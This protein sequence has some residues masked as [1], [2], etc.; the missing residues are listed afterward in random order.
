MARRSVVFTSIA[1]LLAVSVATIVYAQQQKSLKIDV[2]LVMVNVTVTDGDNKLITDLKPD[3]FHIFEDKVEQKIRYFSTEQQ[4]LSLGIVFD[5]SHSMEPKI[6]LAREAAARF[7]ETGGPEDEYFLVEFSSRAKLTEHF[8]SDVARL[9]D[10][11]ALVPP[12][13]DTAMYDAVYLA[14]SEVR[15]GR[16]PKKALLLIT[17]GEDNHSRYSRH[18]IREFARE[19]D[20]QIFSIDLGRALIA[21]LSDMTG[22]H[23]FHGHPDQLEDI[24]GKI[25]QELKN[26]YVV[27]YASTNT[28][29]DGKYRK[30]RV[31][32]TPP[33]GMPK[34]NVRT[35]DGY[36]G[37][38]SPK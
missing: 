35:K 10:H 2:D 5:V 20:V 30:V 9:R 8:T 36:Y 29:K 25:A 38:L 7:L 19:S 17:D 12:Q 4:P 33:E 11:L 28:N 31:R 13:G 22:G 26:Q 6:A 21:D 3:S 14:L 37:P 24:C 15:K 16:N 32:V 27:G 18:D 1:V 23:S 34:F